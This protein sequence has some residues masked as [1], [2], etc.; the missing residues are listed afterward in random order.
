MLKKVFESSYYARE[1]QILLVLEI[2]GD[3]T[4]WKVFVC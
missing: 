3:K 4:E 1:N 2:E